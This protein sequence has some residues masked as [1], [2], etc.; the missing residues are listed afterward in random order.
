[1]TDKT[2]DPCGSVS[3]TEF[4][5][6]GRKEAVSLTKDEER[7]L[8]YFEVRS[9]DAAGTLESARMNAEDFSIAKRWNESGFALFGRI[10][11]DDI[12]NIGGVARDHWCQLSDEAWSAAAAARKARAKRSFQASTLHRIGLPNTISTNT[13]T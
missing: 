7:L 2:P 11:F 1:M 10:A 5:T 9:T 8:L 3:S 12:R 6:A 4:G 13:K